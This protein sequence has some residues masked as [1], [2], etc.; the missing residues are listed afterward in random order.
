M[1][2]LFA[3]LMWLCASTAW[4]KP[5]VGSLMVQDARGRWVPVTETAEATA[6]RGSANPLEISTELGTAR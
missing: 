1:R 4:A 2:L 5:I 3:L 6:T